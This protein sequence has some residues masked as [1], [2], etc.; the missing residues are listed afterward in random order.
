MYPPGQW[1][2]DAFFNNPK[3]P[4]LTTKQLRGDITEAEMVE[5]LIPELERWARK[6]VSRGEDGAAGKGEERGNK[7]EDRKGNGRSTDDDDNNAEHGI[8][9]DRPTAAEMV[10]S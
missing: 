4:H 6:R 7:R 8:S 2:I 9:V 5:V 3:D 10:S 1:R